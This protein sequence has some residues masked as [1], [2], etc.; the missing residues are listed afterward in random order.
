MGSVKGNL[1][2]LKRL[3]LYQREVPF[4]IFMPIPEDAEDPRPDN[5]E[6]EAKEHLIEDI[7][8]TNENFTL[9]SHGFEHLTCPPSWVP[10]STSTRQDVEA[11][12]LPDVEN[13][14]K[15]HVEDVDEIFFFDWRV[16]LIWPSSGRK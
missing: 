2:F 4:Q 6:F 5:L 14:I 12:Y 13:L 8:D 10:T 7:R 16:S 3:D 11:F 15:T 1:Q 9:D